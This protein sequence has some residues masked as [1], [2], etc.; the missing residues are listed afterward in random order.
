MPLTA[1]ANRNNA[2]A[3]CFSKA[4]SLLRLPA[5]RYVLIKGMNPGASPGPRFRPRGGESTGRD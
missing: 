1:T 4:L 2:N 5:G 3:N